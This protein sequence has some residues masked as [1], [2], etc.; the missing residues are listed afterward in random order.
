MPRAYKSREE[1]RQAL[2]RYADDD[3]ISE[4]LEMAQVEEMMVEGYMVCPKEKTMM[5]RERYFKNISFMCLEELLQYAEA[6][7]HV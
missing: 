6:R 7:G 1:I 4:E 3:P 2:T 5:Q